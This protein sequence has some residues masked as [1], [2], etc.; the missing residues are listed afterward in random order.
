MMMYDNQYPSFNL[1]VCKLNIYL[2]PDL[3]EGYQ[4]LQVKGFVYIFFFD[5]KRFKPDK[6]MPNR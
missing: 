4:I 1:Y 2:A 3:L 5:I 6:D